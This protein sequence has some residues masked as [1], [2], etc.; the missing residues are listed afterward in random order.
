[1][2]LAAECLAA[3]TGLWPN[4]AHPSESDRLAAYGLLD[5][6]RSKLNKWL[7]HPGEQEPFEW[8]EPPDQ[9]DLREKILRPIEQ[10]E[11][12]RLIISTGDVDLGREYVAVLTAGRNYLNS[13]WPKIPVPGVPDE[14]FPP[15]PEALADIWN[16]ARILDGD[17]ALMDEISSYSVTVDM[18]DAWK[19]NRP[20]LADEVMKILQ[21][22][23]ISEHGLLVELHADGKKLSW[24]QQNVLAMLI[25]NPRE[26]VPASSEEDKK[27]ETKIAPSGNTK[28]SEHATKGETL[29]KG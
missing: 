22:D 19:M 27:Q 5:R 15:T 21:G 23:G 28:A 25:G 9:A 2:S 11:A 3:T 4:K 26:E 10:G 24:Q 16:Q 14:I 29:G 8:V 13:K 12:E 6:W 20:E 7:R 17:G 1:M 18:I